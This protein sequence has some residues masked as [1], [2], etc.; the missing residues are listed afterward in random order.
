VFSLAREL[1]MTVDRLMREM[2]S[3]ELVHWMAYSALERE[4]M[5]TRRDKAA[6][7]EQV[8]GSR[9]RR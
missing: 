8:R 1:G 5:E 9:G 6:V 2:T 7:T 4:D 3:D